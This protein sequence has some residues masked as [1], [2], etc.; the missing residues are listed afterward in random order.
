MA[1]INFDQELDTYYLY[2]NLKVLIINDLLNVD[3]KYLKVKVIHLLGR[4]F[5]L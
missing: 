3:T 2:H 1:N 4:N 5:L